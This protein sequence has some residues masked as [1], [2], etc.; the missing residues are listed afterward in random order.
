[1]SL[2]LPTEAKPRPRIPEW[3]RRPLPTS[4]AFNHT[5]ALALRSTLNER[6]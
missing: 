6:S 2:S 3:L 1:M 5:S 4:R